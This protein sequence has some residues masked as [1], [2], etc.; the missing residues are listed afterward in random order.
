[1]LGMVGTFTSTFTFGV[2]T[3]GVRIVGALMPVVPPPVILMPVV[4]MSA[5]LMPVV[6]TFASPPCFK[7]PVA[8]GYFPSPRP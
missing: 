5:L 7:A 8:E 2:L 3:A 1:M 6:E 4:L